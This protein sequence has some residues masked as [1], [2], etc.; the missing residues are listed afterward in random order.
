MKNGKLPN[1]NI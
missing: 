1:Y